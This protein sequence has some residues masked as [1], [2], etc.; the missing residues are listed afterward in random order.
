MVVL[1]VVEVVMAVIRRQKGKFS[2]EKTSK[3]I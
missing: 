2:G 1:T 3:W